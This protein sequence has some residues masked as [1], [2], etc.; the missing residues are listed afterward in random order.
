MVAKGHHFPGV[1]L[2]AVVDADTGLALPDFRADE[3]TFQLVTQLAGPQRSRRAREGDRADVPARR[4]AAPVRGSPRRRRLPRRGASRRRELGYPPFRHLISIVASGSDAEAPS[5]LLR[6]LN[7]RAHRR[8]AARAGAVAPSPRPPPGAARRQ[9][10]SAA[11]TRRRG[12]LSSW[13]RPRPRCGGQAS[14]RSSTS[15]RNRSSASI[16]PLSDGRAARRH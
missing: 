12:P 3:R 8:R 1:S 5:R 15:T 11:R 2:A 16:P 9:D 7:A 10:R 4:H 14:A 13:P 6:E